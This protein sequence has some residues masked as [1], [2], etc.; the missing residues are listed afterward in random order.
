MNRRDTIIGLVLL[1]LAIALP[2]MFST[3]YVITQLTLFFI[4]ATVVMQWNLVFGVAGIFSLAQMALFAFGAYI[5]AMLTLYFGISLWI[6]M[7]IGAIGTVVLSV[8]IGW[9]CLRLRGPYVALLTFAVS[10]AMLILLITDVEC[11]RMDGTI[12]LQFTGGV[13]G[14]SRYGDF[15]FRELLGYSSWHIGNYFVALA[16]L[17]L[18]SIFAFAIIRSPLGFT[19]R[20]LRDNEALAMASGVSRFK[21]Q[22]LVFALSAFF[23]GLAGGVYAGHFRVVG[24]NLLYLSLLVYL[25]AMLV[26][27]GI[28]RAWGPL[29]G[30]AVLMTADEFL[31]EVVDFRNI[32]IGLVIILCTVLLP[33]GVVGGLAR[34]TDRLRRRWAAVPSAEEAPLIHGADP[35]RT[36]T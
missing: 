20:A 28:G 16:L 35:K 1:A 27:G 22:L 8:L 36:E 7:F 4:W 15:G 18:G 3:R 11:F 30:A 2:F 34:L 23:T 17:S 29:V 5:T 19:F 31:R 13:K 26:V 9:S 25:V 24:P 32:G 21:Y 12:C 6:S 10:Q 33:G 14:F